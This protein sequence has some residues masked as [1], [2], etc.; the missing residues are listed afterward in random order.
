MEWNVVYNTDEKM[1]I[2]R[3]VCVCVYLYALLI[4]PKQRYAYDDDDDGNGWMMR[5]WMARVVLYGVFMCVY[6]TRCG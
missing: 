4:I 6:I 5:M 3:C 1:V 2:I